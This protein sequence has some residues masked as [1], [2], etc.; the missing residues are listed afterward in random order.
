[1][2]VLPFSESQARQINQIKLLSLPDLVLHISVRASTNHFISEVQGCSELFR[3]N[4]KTEVKKVGE[5]P[6]G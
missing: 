2:A 6:I 5:C 3:E 4:S 1:M